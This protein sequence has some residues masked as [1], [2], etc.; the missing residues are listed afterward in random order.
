VL[1]PWTQRLE[2]DDVTKE[3]VVA[4]LGQVDGAIRTTEAR[5]KRAG[6]RVE[7]LLEQ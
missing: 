1:Q 3:V 7:S 4:N 5:W 6:E 2:G